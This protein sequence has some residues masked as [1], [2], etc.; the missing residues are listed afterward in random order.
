MSFVNDLISKF[1]RGGSSLEDSDSGGEH[2]RQGFEK[3]ESSYAEYIAPACHYNEYTILNKGGELVQIIKIEDYVCRAPSVSLR[4]VIRKSIINIADGNVAFWLYTVREKKKFHLEWKDTG[5]FSDV[6][7]GKHESISS[8]R[9]ETYANTVYIAVVV[10][11]LPEG[12][13]SILGALFSRMVIKKHKHYLSTHAAYLSRITSAIMEALEGFSVSKLGLIK[14]K[15]GKWR[16][17]LLEFLSYVVTLK[18][19]E[20]FLDTCDNAHT[21]AGGCSIQMG[22]NAFRVTGP[23]GGSKYGAIL[24][25]KSYSGDC[26]EAINSCIQQPC[27]FIIVEVLR[28]VENKE[29]KKLY[30]KQVEL[31]EVS[32]DKSLVETSILQEVGALKEGMGECCESKVT[33]LV[34]GDSLFALKEEINRMVAAFS[35]IGAVVTRM[36]IAMEDCFWAN[37]PGNFRY[38]IGMRAGLINAACNFTML[39]EFP[40]GCLKGGKWS[41]AITMFFSAAGFPYFFSFHAETRGHTVCLGPNDFDMTLLINFILSEARRLSVKSVVFDYSGKSVIYSLA[42]GGKYHRIDS[43]QES[44]SASFSPFHV[45]DTKKNREIAVEVLCRMV[46]PVRQAT[47]ELKVAVSEAVA[48]IFSVSEDSRTPEKISECIGN[49]GGKVGNWIGKGQFAHLITSSSNIE[50]GA[51]F[52]AI[53]AGMLVGKQECIS[54][55]LYYLLH[56]MERH[57]KGSPTILVMYEAWILDTVFLSEEEFDSW[58]KRL[59]KL[60]VVVVFASENIRAMTASRVFRYMNKHVETRI[61]MPNCI[62]ESKQYARTLGLSQEEFDTM[63]QISQSEGHFFLK[64]GN[65]SVVL[66]L[67]L[68]KREKR[69]LS[70]NR[71]TIKLM[72]DVIAEKGKSWLDEFHARCDALEK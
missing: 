49:L 47:K 69:V 40:S 55:I 30:S 33:C 28:F 4:E 22:F 25:V 56:S 64:Q 71:T 46:S 12:M 48:N 18:R 24:G 16:S 2:T 50:W 20:C 15:G 66:T 10:G 14:C 35:T 3:A 27:E 57:L 70:A 68:P 23:A 41:E 36:D 67:N 45:E 34:V 17:E 19:Q 5:D 6:L 9:Y 42:I 13:N 11:H 1:R 58:I 59:E 61:F 53:N 60:N 65:S 8:E 31:L 44:T 21:I 62:V 29:V 54:V 63:L 39:N 38:V 26:A 52:L 7:H 43:R 37:M 72:Y 51:E 32:G